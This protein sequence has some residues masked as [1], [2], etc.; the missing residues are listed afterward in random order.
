MS[1]T[2]IDPVNNKIT[3]ETRQY[4]PV[5]TPPVYS[6][7]LR[8]WDGWNFNFYDNIS[9]TSV[10]EGK[11]IVVDIYNN[12]GEEFENFTVVNNNGIQSVTLP[13]GEIISVTA[14]KKALADSVANASRLVVMTAHLNDEALGKATFI[15]E[16]GGDTSMWAVNDV[17]Y[18]SGVVPGAL[19][20]EEQPILSPVAR[21]LVADTKENGGKI[22]IYPTGVWNPT[23]I[24]QSSGQNRTQSLSTTPQPITAYD[25]NAFQLNTI[26][27]HVG[28]V[29]LTTQ[30]SPG[31]VGASGYYTIGF[32]LTI[33]STDNE[34]FLFEVYK[35][36]LPS[37]IL[38][39]IDLRNPN[40]DAGS[41][42]LNGIAQTAPLLITDVIELYGYTEG[43]N[44][45][46][47]YVS[48]LFNIKREGNE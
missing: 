34:L 39:A 13:S 3:T 5:Y 7:G 27:L 30:I 15:G 6:P 40:I 26:V 37:G 20:N 9:G 19:T 38:S 44:A 14:G 42:S 22:L 21:V 16:A 1:K 48:C 18:L 2:I 32:N 12:S 41:C 36:G 23:A 24:G 31:S 17:L 25:D 10:Q 11:E 29:N 45:D 28:T 35:N 46:L 4:L 47:E 43:G 33:N 8:W